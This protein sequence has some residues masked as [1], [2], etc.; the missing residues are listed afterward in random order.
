MIRIARH[1][2][3]FFGLGAALIVISP[4]S[5][6]AQAQADTTVPIAP[7]LRALAR[8]WGA[9]VLVIDSA[10]IAASTAPTF[11]ELLQARLP[12]LRVLRS[13]GMASDGSLVMLRG[14]I[15]S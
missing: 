7:L 10:Q 15:S 11:S 3:G 4:F 6:L 14:P 8:E 9:N 12:G 2:L 1:S 13:G 5:L